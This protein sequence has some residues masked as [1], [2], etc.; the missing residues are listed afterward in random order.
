[1]SSDFGVTVSSQNLISN[2][3]PDQRVNLTILQCYRRVVLLG[4][5]FDQPHV[6]C[7]ARD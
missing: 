2:L 7:G 5:Y 4:L 3:G 1:M 6:L